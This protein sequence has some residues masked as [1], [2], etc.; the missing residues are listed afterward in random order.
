MIE[1][2]YNKLE[3]RIAKLEA[4]LKSSKQIQAEEKKILISEIEKNKILEQR[5]RALMEALKLLS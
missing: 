3:S 4:E 1:E 5:N 2:H